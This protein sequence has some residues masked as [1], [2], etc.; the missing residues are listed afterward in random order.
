MSTSP[1]KTHKVRNSVIIAL[2]AVAVAFSFGLLAVKRGETINAIWLLVAA[3][4]SYALGYRFYA[5]WIGRRIM[6]LD[7]NRAT[8]AV[9]NNDGRDF[10]P[11]N[12]YVLF[13]HHFAAIAGAGPL[14]GP[15][16][17]AQMGWLP[18]TLLIILGA[19]FAG[20]VQDFVVLFASTR[21][22]GRSLGEIARNEIG[23]VGGWFALVGTLMMA[24]IV[25]AVLALVVTNAL[26]GSPWGTFL[27]AMTI[28]IALLMGVYLRYLRPGRTFE[29]TALGVV[30]LIAAL[31]FGQNVAASPVLGPIFTLDG[32]T[33][34]IFIMIYG[35]LASILPVWLLLVPRD[36]LSTFL[37]IGTMVLLAV[38][39]II[40]H[41]QLQMT[42]VTRFIDGTGPVFAGNLF[43]F[44]FIT[45]ACGALSGWHTVISSGTTPKLVSKET[46]IP[47]L[48]YAGMLTESFVAIMAMIAACIL[49]P[50][51]YFAINSPASAIGT[52]AQQAAQTISS[53]GFTIDAATIE[54]TARNVEE[55][56]ILS[57]TG[58][59]PSLAVGMAHIFA[60]FLGGPAIMKFWY[61]F[62]ILFE[63]VFILTTV[64]A[65]TRV[66]RFMFQG[67]IG[68]GW[69]KFGD[70]EWY[71]A[72]VMASA[73][74]VAIWGYFLYAGVTNPFGGI[75]TLW[76]LFGIANQ[77]LGAT[78][79]VIGTTVFIKMGKAKWSFVTL[80][81]M[82]FMY[83]TT[84]TAALEKI[85]SP[86][87]K[88]GFWSH[89]NMLAKQLAAGHI[90]APATTAAQAQQVIFNDR[91]DAILCGVF[92]VIM[93]GVLADAMRIWAKVVLQK[94]QLKLDEEP[95]RDRSEF[96]AA[97]QG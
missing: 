66:G 5:L 23:P 7:A 8:P 9:V 59:A 87:P 34:A 88:L 10:V 30:L 44:L 65:G 15:T 61:H 51:L 68:R 37:K 95:Y 93:L 58:G 84:W 79:L 57:R 38:G 11:T 45:I 33:L 90:P 31:I 67:L 63:A 74:T 92:L 40:V 13:G 80:I 71:P 35:F 25:L 29:A 56:T 19:V 32:P 3:L 39:I 86:D 26:R 82:L 17:A 48:G 22:N 46:D 14:V 64:D 16:L 18:G 1:P 77:M 75:N 89:A 73:L 55:Q 85:F 97:A 4:G 41:P 69:K 91:L 81:P 28:P 12:R 96:E 54:Q 24:M 72:T 76:P 50:G 6:G 47:M 27:I 70:V 94:K 21:R 60:Q 43:P 2:I 83:V 20:A 42:G 52:T 36:Y 49:T 78:A 62:A 53:W